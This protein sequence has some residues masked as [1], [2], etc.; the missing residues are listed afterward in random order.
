MGGPLMRSGLTD[1]AWP[2]KCLVEAGPGSLACGG[3]IGNGGVGM[4]PLLGNVELLQLR[5]VGLRMPSQSGSD[6]F[7]LNGRA[8][9]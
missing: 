1:I 2:G 3:P 4:W 7:G 5:K 6:R 8:D 9:R